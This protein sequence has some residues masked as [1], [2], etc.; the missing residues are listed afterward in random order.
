[1][2]NTLRSR[3]PIGPTERWHCWLN[4]VGIN[5]ENGRLI[6]PGG[7]SIVG[8]SGLVETYGDHRMQMTALVLA[9]GSQLPCSLRVIT[10]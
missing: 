10:A 1:M 4:L 7:Q 6:V 8:P 9:M 2:L 3:K 5:G